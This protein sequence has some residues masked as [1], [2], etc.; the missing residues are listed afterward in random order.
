MRGTD[1]TKSKWECPIMFYICSLY[2]DVSLNIIKIYLFVIVDSNVLYSI[3]YMYRCTSLDI[4]CLIIIACL[5]L[6]AKLVYLQNYNEEQ[7]S[8][9]RIFIIVK[10]VVV[11]IL[12]IYLIFY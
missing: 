9:G 5:Y 11:K 2:T 1:P 7:L 12:R 3:L 8:A 4:L 10:L 6:N